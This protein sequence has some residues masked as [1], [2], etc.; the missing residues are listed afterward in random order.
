M[1]QSRILTTPGT[2]VCGRRA[3]AA[4]AA[5]L[6][7]WSATAGAEPKVVATIPPIH[8]LA[9]AVMDG[10]G[11][12]VLLIPGGRSPHDFAL[13]PS[14]ARLLQTAEIILWSG[15]AAEPV[16]GRPLRALAGAATTLTLAEAPGVRRLRPREGGVW[17]TDHDHGAEPHADATAYDGHIWLSPVNAKAMVAAIAAALVV[18]DAANAP[19]YRANADAAARRIDALDRTLRDRLAPVRRRP[20]VVF[21]DAYQYFERHY[22]LAPAGAITVGPDRLPGARR[23]KAIRRVLASRDVRCVFREPQFDPALV[24]TITSGTQAHAGTLDPLGAG[25]APGPDQW[26][27]LMRSLADSLRACLL[28]SG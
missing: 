24:S 7:L 22:G 25:L 23:L 27:A 21:H 6:A 20:Y 16:M 11:R 3:G 12:P 17:K 8:G 4:L 13:R 18:R 15:P 2:G 1:V 26:F 9:A 5:A 10:V 19:R 14:D 28:A